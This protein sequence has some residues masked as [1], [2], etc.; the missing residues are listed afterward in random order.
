MIC[1]TTRG[2]DSDR[3]ARSLFRGRLESRKLG[4]VKEFISDT[5][6]QD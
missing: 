5:T 1:V 2:K 6:G 3:G 4:K